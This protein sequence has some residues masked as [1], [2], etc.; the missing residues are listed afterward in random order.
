MAGL[1]ERQKVMRRRA[2]IDSALQLFEQQ[3]F[4]A[5]TV[6]QIAEAASVSPATVFNY[7]GSKN[8]IL[9]EKLLEADRDV[10]ARERKRILSLD[11][12]EEVLF[13]LHMVTCNFCLNTLS[14]HLWRELLP[15]VMM[16]NRS[17]LARGYGILTDTYVSEVEGI[18]NQ[19]RERQILRA[20]LDLSLTA[21]VLSDLGHAVMARHI[22]EEGFSSDEH[23]NQ[24]KKISQLL[25][26]GIRPT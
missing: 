9:L 17:E 26:N 2:I 25:A 19:L 10:W 22:V 4:N 5:T 3:G 23:V 21:R 11:S 16:G 15:L 8:E 13:E 7:F 20:D 24:V 6:E 12:V 14:A 1:R 18:L